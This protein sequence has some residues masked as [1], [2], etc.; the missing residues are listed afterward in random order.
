MRIARVLITADGVGGVWQFTSDLTRALTAD[1]VDVT[2]AAMG[3]ALSRAQRAEAHSIGAALV[4]GA[5]RLEWMDDPWDDVDRAGEWLLDLEREL[6]PDVVHLNGFCHGNLPWDAPAVIV[7]HSCVRSWWRAVHGD[8]PPPSWSRYTERVRAGVRAAAMVI[9]PTAAMAASLDEEYGPLHTLRIVPNGRKLRPSAANKEPLVFSA[10]RLW[11]EAKNIQSVCAAARDL[12]WPVVVAGD[13]RHPDGRAIEPGAVRYLG[14]LSAHEMQGWFA[15]A[16][17]Y[18][19]PA[20]YEP[21][22]LSVLEAALSGC[23]LVLGDIASLRENWDGAAVFVPS[24]DRRAIA[25][26]VQ[27]LIDDPRLLRH[28]AARAQERARRFP[29]ERMAA[30]YLDA[31]TWLTQQSPSSDRV[32]YRR[33]GTAPRPITAA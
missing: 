5:F 8:E 6:R 29:V 26:G 2:I 4:E 16:S 33:T 11:D 7:G 13:N 17:I 24:D 14:M 9:A 20:R 31:Y 25:A 32:S 1:G 30:G 19:L 28:Y 22:G 12:S 15:R 21:F 23:A 3:P 10:G 18:A 27:Q